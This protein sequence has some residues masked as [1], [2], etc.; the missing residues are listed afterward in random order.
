MSVI[1]T[2]RFIVDHPLNRGHKKAALSRFLKWQVGA[3]LVP[4]PVVVPW[5]GNTR[6]IVRR[7]DKG[8]TQ[9]IYCGLRDF[10]E[11]SYLAHVLSSTDLFLDVGAN[12][13]AYTVLARAEGSARNLF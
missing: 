3:R 1:D 2:L 7:G 12:V 10:P 13:G 4:G 11:M 8:F 9:N 6:M 5:V